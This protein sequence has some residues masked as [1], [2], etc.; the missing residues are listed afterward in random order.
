MPWKELHVMDQKLEFVIKSF[1]PGVNFTEL[2]REY[3]ISTKTG[4]KWKERFLAEGIE[5]LH[6]QSRKPHNNPAQLT[7]EVVCE[8]IRIKQTKKT[9]GPKKIRMVYARMHSGES[10]PSLSTVERVL[11]KAGFVQPKRRRSR[12]SLSQ[13]I[14]NPTTP[15]QPNDLWTVDFKGW[16]YTPT[17]E[18]CEPLTVRDEYSKYIL[19]IKIL[20]NGDITSVKREFERLFTKYGLPKVIKSDNGPPFASARSILGLTR[21]SAWWMSLGI[22]LDRIT[23][24]SPQENGAHERM[25]LDI[26]KELEG[27][28]N[29]S[30][31]LHQNVFDIWKDEFNTERPHESLGM[32]T[33][34]SVYLKSERVFIND[35]EYVVYPYEMIRRQVNSRGYIDL[36]GRRVF[37]SN[38]FAAYTIGLKIK[39]NLF[40]EVWFYNHYV[41]EI[42]L[43]TYLFKSIL[44][45]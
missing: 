36:K 35:P 45:K 15:K 5:G 4:Y 27:K 2:C 39:S 40:Y 23:P 25:H 41:G 24:G 38:A 26:K 17:K 8:L 29:G 6:N 37:I 22:L 10:L 9:W 7:E 11:K 30:L 3:G 28:V 14:E 1:S 32:K 12:I 42:D 16:W 19:S 33:P 21:L 44:D 31:I 18:K 34:S 13:R 20:E 43:Q